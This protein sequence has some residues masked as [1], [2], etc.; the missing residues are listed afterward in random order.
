MKLVQNGFI[1]LMNEGRILF[2]ISDKTDRTGRAGESPVSFTYAYDTLPDPSAPVR[3][4]DDSDFV[5]PDL[6]EF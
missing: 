1:P 4:I 2:F 6:M 3:E 5:V